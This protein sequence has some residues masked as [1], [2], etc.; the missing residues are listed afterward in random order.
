MENV[1]IKRINDAGDKVT[2]LTIFKA[3]ESETCYINAHGRALN[4]LHCT[5]ALMAALF[6][7]SGCPSFWDF[8][9]TLGNAAEKYV[10]GNDGT[11]S[12]E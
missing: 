1:K 8:V 9:I 6:E 5:A 11:G 2:C 7:E 4:L 10:E 3:E 12:K